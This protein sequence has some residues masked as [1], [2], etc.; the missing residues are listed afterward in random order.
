MLA[1]RL[2]TGS[3]PHAGDETAER[4]DLSV[5]AVAMVHSGLTW[6]FLALVVVLS[7]RLR[8]SGAPGAV[9]DR[10]QTL[11]TV[12]VL[13]GAIGYVQYVTGVPELLVG[14]HVLGSMVVW[15][16]ALRLRLTAVEPVP[17]VGGTPVERATDG[18]AAT[19]LSTSP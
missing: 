16:A 14:L 3:G 1:G 7:L 9:I 12:V 13:Q 6:L 10:A 11:L 2:V 19:H 18:A 15:V 4:L 5:R 17:A 8:R